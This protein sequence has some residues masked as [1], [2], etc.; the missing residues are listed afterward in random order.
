LAYNQTHITQWTLDVTDL[1]D[2]AI[3]G[4]CYW[5]QCHTSI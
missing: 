3:D 2:N 1:T 5:R 4:R